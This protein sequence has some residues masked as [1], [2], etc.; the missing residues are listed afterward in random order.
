MI[1]DHL[2]IMAHK[3]AGQSLIHFATEEPEVIHFAI[4]NYIA[5]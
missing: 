1:N 2:V 3:P 5:S 4:R